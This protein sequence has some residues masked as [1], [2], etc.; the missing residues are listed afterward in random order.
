MMFDFKSISKNSSILLHVKRGSNKNIVVKNLLHQLLNN[1]QYSSGVVVSK[2]ETIEPFYKLISDGFVY[3]SCNDEQL[4]D[5]INKKPE[6]IIL[7]DIDIIKT[8]PDVMIINIVQSIEDINLDDFDYVFLTKTG[9]EGEIKKICKYCDRETME[10]IFNKYGM[11]V[12]KNKEV[13]KFKI[14]N[15]VVIDKV[16]K[17]VE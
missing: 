7:D 8:S 13:F 14:D 15:D 4:Q 17:F 11:M 16:I 6:F 1:L 9:I 5:I 2:S 3:N 12:I 10:D